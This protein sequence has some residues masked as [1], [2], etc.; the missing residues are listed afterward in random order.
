MQISPGCVH[1]EGRAFGTALQARVGQ[2]TWGKLCG[3]S[4]FSVMESLRAGPVPKASVRRR[5][6]RE[7]FRVLWPLEKKYVWG[8]TSITLTWAT[9]LPMYPSFKIPSSRSRSF[10]RKTRVTMSGRSLARCP[11]SKASVISGHPGRNNGNHDGKD[12]HNV[13]G[14]CTVQALPCTFTVMKHLNHQSHGHEAFEPSIANSNNQSVR[15][16][17][18]RWDTH[19]GYM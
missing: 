12:G 4:V 14:V 2:R 16:I 7:S 9:A 11:S 17:K 5:N 15:I 10:R 18:G 8:R 3:G 6:S 13:E 19:V 1:E